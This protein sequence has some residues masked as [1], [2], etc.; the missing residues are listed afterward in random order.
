M[1]TE[2]TSPVAHASNVL[3]RTTLGPHASSVL[4]SAMNNAA[5]TNKARQSPRPMFRPP[6]SLSRD[7]TLKRQDLTAVSPLHNSGLSPDSAGSRA[8]VLCAGSDIE[9]SRLDQCFSSV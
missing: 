1:V 2:T 9:A 7:L 6:S 8:F 4:P 5:R 3:P